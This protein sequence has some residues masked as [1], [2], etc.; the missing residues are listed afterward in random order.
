[1]Y[2]YTS[3]WYNARPYPRKTS[4]R[5]L[6]HR[7]LLHEKRPSPRS[8]GPGLIEL[9]RC[10]V[11]LVRS[12]TLGG[13]SVGRSL[14]S[15][16]ATI[17][18]LAHLGPLGLLVGHGAGLL[19]EELLEAVDGNDE[20]Q[21]HQQDGED[22]LQAL[23]GGDG[24][25]SRGSGGRDGTE[26]AVSLDSG[27]AAHGALDQRGEGAAEQEG[28]GHVEHPALRPVHLQNTAR[29]IMVIPP[30]SWLEAPKSGQMLA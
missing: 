16:G 10:D 13:L 20:A 14:S 23:G 22:E 9:Y 6:G 27:H 2:T 1:M 15:S 17:L 24:D 11:Q 5:T 21:D 19:A 28:D 4:A 29:V 3:I 25:G 18:G 7:P 12:I 30:S 8:R 26:E